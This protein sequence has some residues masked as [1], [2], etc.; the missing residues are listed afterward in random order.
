[1]LLHRLITPQ[2]QQLALKPFNLSREHPL[3]INGKPLKDLIQLLQL[4]LKDIQSIAIRPHPILVGLMIDLL[5]HIFKRL[6]D[7]IPSRIKI[8]HMYLQ[9]IVMHLAQTDAFRLLRLEVF[10]V[11]LP[12]PFYHFPQGIVEP[13]EQPLLSL[14]LLTNGLRIFLAIL[15]L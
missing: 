15:A 13:M 11:V 2:I 12:H 1:M 14:V 10:E 3:I 9:M 8:I 7:I 4:M 6:L 5:H